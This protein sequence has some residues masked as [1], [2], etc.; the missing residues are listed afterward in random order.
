MGI[1]FKTWGS[2]GCEVR[3]VDD[4]Y[5]VRVRT[6]PWGYGRAVYQRLADGRTAVYAHLSAFVGPARE[7]V[8][9]AQ[10]T[11]QRYS[12]DLWFK[13]GEIPVR[14][15]DVI[16]LSGESG[17]G[18]PHLH[19][20]LRDEDNKPINPLLKDYAVDD[21]TPP[22]MRRIGLVPP[23]ERSCAAS[24]VTSRSGTVTITCTSS[25]SSVSSP[26]PTLPSPPAACA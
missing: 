24:T 8:E 9:V 4:G 11:A 2:I 10:R 19:F 25:S 23:G 14:R 20:E 12:V 21:T 1:D 22:V 16:A 13:S 3:A 5:I 7:R 26:T 6:S 18:P 17:A 15:G